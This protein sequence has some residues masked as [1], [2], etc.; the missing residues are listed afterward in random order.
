MKSVSIIGAGRMGGALAIALTRAGVPVRQLV[1]R[2]ERELSSIL[3]ACPEIRSV[4]G[5]AALD[6][7]TSDVVIIATGDAEIAAVAG[8]LERS[9]IHGLTI[10]HTSGALSSDVLSSLSASG[11]DI[12]S[13]HPLVSISDPVKGSTSFTAIGFCVEGKEPAVA[14]ALALVDRLEGKPFEIPTGLKPLY[15]ASAVMSS[16]HVTALFDI[17]VE[18]LVKC[19]LTSDEALS[20]LGPLLTSTV[21]NIRSQGTTDALTGSFARFDVEVIRKHLSLLAE[22]GSNEALEIYRMLGER[23]T[24]IAERKYGSSERS[25]LV[26]EALSEHG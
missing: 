24:M 11:N 15:H 19:G 8:E 23:S 10:L 17:A 13:I 9:G 12:G 26:H 16:G 14:D 21:D 6:P 7:N 5:V 25:S 22:N 20:V 2:G 4:K 18:M 1:Y 3:N